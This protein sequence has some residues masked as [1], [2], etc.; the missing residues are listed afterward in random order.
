MMRFFFVYLS[1]TWGGGSCLPVPFISGAGNLTHTVVWRTRGAQTL[2]T[3]WFGGPAAR[4][5]YAHCG[6]E[7]ERRPNLTRNMVW[8]PRAAQT[9][10][11]I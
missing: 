11:G 7:T 9:L 8:G 4:K 6:L 3:R 5:P 2:L 10:R 1:P